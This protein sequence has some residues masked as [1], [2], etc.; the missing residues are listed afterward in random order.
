MLSTEDN[1]YLELNRKGPTIPSHSEKTLWDPSAGGVFHRLSSGWSQVA[2]PVP[3]RIVVITESENSPASRS[4]ETA[5]PL[6]FKPR[7]ESPEASPSGRDCMA[8]LLHLRLSYS[9]EFQGK[10]LGVLVLNLS[11]QLE[12]EP[13]PSQPSPSAQWSSDSAGDSESVISRAGSTYLGLSPFQWLCRHSVC[14]LPLFLD[15]FYSWCW[16]YSWF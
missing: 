2:H 15:I 13:A 14:W 4:W 9:R 6:G 1:V 12:S 8:V 7:A 3:E 10:A 11:Q 5:S 16:I